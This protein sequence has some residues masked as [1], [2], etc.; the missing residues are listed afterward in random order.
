MIS[1]LLFI[2]LLMASKVLIA[3]PVFS[4]MSLPIGKLVFWDG[5]V[6]LLKNTMF[7]SDHTRLR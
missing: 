1:E 3:E 4:L 2:F 7:V 6:T 5:T